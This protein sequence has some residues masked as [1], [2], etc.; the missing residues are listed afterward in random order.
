MMEAMWRQTCM[1]MRWTMKNWILRK[2]E[3]QIVDYE[4]ER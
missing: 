1:A 3:S 2:K 4:Q